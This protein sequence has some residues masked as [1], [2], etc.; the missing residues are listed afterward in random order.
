MHKGLVTGVQVG[1]TNNMVRS[2]GEK[3]ARK[4]RTPWIEHTESSAAL[5]QETWVQ[6]ATASA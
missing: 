6:H 3:V 5:D 2:G 4:D 1:W